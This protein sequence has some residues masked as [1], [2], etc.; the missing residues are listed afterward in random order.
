MVPS[1][2]RLGRIVPPVVR[3]KISVGSVTLPAPRRIELRSNSFQESV[4]PNRKAP[5]RPVQISSSVTSR[6]VVFAFAPRSRA[7][8]SIRRS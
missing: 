6:K 5:S 8:S 1:A 7:A 4:K 2:Y 3:P